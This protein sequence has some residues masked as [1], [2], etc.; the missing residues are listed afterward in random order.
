MDAEVTWHLL[1]ELVYLLV[2]PHW[3]GE[4]KIDLHLLCVTRYIP[5]ECLAAADGTSYS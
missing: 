3:K 5:Q 1:H 4:S 2:G